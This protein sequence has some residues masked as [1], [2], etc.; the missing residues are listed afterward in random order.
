MS[1]LTTRHT[2]Q[3][4]LLARV[5]DQPNLVAAV[6]ALPARALG[7]LIDHVGLEDAGEIVALA[8]TPQL[9]RIFDDD[10]WQSPGPGKD[11]SFDADRFALWLEVMLEAGEEF[12]ARKLAELPED[13]VTL[14][15][16]KQV[17]VI[18][19]EQMAMSMSGRYS[20][21]DALVEKALESCLCEEIDEYRIISRR[22]DGWDAILSVL[23]ALDRDHNAFL[24]RVL[25]RCCHMAG[26]FIEDNGGLYQVLTSDTMLES[27][28][29]AERE[30]RRAGEGFIAPSSAASLLALARTTDLAS[31]VA[32]RE[33][34]PVTRA[35]FRSLEGPSRSGNARDSAK[36]QASDDS[37]KASALIELLREAEVLPAS[38]SIPLLR[39]AAGARSAQTDEVFTRAMHE[40]RGH[41]ANI[42]D[43]RMQELAYLANVL[44]AGCSIESRAMRPVEAAHAAVATC[45]L[46]LEHLL[47]GL[48][49]PAV[50][51]LRDESADKLFRIGWRL[52]NERIVLPA[53]RALE[54]ILARERKG[55]LARAIEADLLRTAH[56]LHTAISAGTPWVVWA[57]LTA[58]ASLVEPPTLTAL[59]ALV[60]ECPSL[61]GALAPRKGKGKTSDTEATVFIATL[62]QLRSAEQFIARA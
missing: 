3:R 18:N 48:D 6:Q 12:T 34:D 29:G 33:R 16:H 20:N 5:L 21:D 41:A 31:T 53:A 1:P 30:E 55:D 9:K 17:L 19:I 54:G 39:E 37:T 7:K 27:D 61:A 35:Y 26:E 25:E 60:D 15:L 62:A 42:H 2:A 23:L 36:P 4:D 13:L 43:R 51:V 10:L 59:L 22:H 11:E 57:K 46:G 32:S 44:G 38:R 24:Q 58:L 52:H 14:A 50:E 56:A 40:L 47:D 49:E 28:V 45:N 8:T